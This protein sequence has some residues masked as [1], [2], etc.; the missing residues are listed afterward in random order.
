MVSD[1]SPGAANPKMNESCVHTDTAQRSSDRACAQDGNFKCPHPTI[2]DG[3]IWSDSG[4]FLGGFGVVGRLTRDYL[5]GSW[6]KKH[7]PT[8]A[9]AVVPRP[10]W[11]PPPGAAAYNSQP[12]CCATSLC[13]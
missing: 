6:V 10:P 4:W 7:T 9:A 13:R 8:M 12:T 1:A 3:D 11:C 2:I 5:G